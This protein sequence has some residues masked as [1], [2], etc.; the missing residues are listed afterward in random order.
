MISATLKDVEFWMHLG[1]PAEARK[2]K[3]IDVPFLSY[4]TYKPCLEANAYMHHLTVQRNL[5]ASTLRTYASYI[6]HLI[7]FIENQPTLSRFSQLT[8]SSF[9]L[10]IQNLT[11]ETKLNGEPKRSSTEVAKIGETCIQFL[12]FVQSFHD[13]THFIGQEDACAISVIEK[14]HSIQ[15]EGRKEKK[16]VITITHASL[17]K[18]GAIKKR[19]PVSQEDALKVWEHISTQKKD[20]SHIKDP[21][22]KR[23][24][25]REQYDKRKRDKAIYVAMETL[26]GRVGELHLLQYN[27]LVEARTSGSLRIDTLKKRNDDNN[28]R[29]LPVDHIFLDQMDSYL[30]VRKRIMKKFNV[31]HNYL[32]I[33]LN[34]GQPLSANTWKKYINDW[35]TELGIE[36]R[37]SPHLWRHSRFTNWMIDRI[38]ASKEINSKDDFRKNVLHTMQFKKEL[39]QFSGHTL[40]SSLDIYLDLAWEQLHGY[41]KVYSAAS[42]K[43]TVESVERRIEDIESQMERNE[44]TVVQ[45]ME[46]VKSL[47]SAFKTD[48]DN[49]IANESKGE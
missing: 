13:L 39:Q 44:L 17:P 34:D 43:T 48:I 9:R 5:K 36:G 14:K 28:E 35:G 15:I 31:K 24:A 47:L 3:P 21:K 10:F 11:L 32:F 33:S 46:S 37:I 23:L 2:L 16:E 45:A 41:T 38:L 4:S 8:D 49:A 12:Q 19:H 30:D 22:S 42:L 1:V 29:Y 6:V 26:G 7:R 27:D 40:I 25:K 20:I 18:K